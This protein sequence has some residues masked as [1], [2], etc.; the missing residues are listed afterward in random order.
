MLT[1]NE[2]ANLL[3]ISHRTLQ[4][5]RIKGEGP[6]FVSVGRL[7]RYRQADLD[8]WLES[9]KSA[10]TSALAASGGAR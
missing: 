10:S 3:S 9:R 5:W 7:V 8:A 6:L 2:A 1:E 4:A